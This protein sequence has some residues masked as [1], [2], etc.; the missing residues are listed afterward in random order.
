VAIRC[1]D[2]TRLNGD[3]RLAPLNLDSI[4]ISW[5][6]KMPVFFLHRTEIRRSMESVL[7]SFKVFIDDNKNIYGSRF[8]RAM[9]KDSTLVTLISLSATYPTTA[10]VYQKIDSLRQYMNSQG[11]A[12]I[13]SP[14]LNVTKLLDGTFRTMVAIPGNKRLAGHGRIANQHFVPWRMLEGE[15]HGGVYTVE[16]AFDQL[17]KFKTDHGMS[18][19]ALPFQSLVTD[20]R[21]EQDTTKWVTIVCAAIS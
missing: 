19:M 21:K 15:V 7:R 1:P 5:D 10:E 11:A 6:C 16:K 13:D 17:Q 2:G 20:R 4:L 18:I 8:F 3:I 14:W 12:A 9:S